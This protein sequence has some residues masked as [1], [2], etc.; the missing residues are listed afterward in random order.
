MSWDDIQ[1]KRNSGEISNTTFAVYR[2]QKETWFPDNSSEW[3]GIAGKKTIEKIIEALKNKI[4]D[5]IDINTLSSEANWEPNKIWQP[6]KKQIGNQS[7]AFKK[8]MSNTLMPLVGKKE[9]NPNCQ[10]F[11]EKPFKWLKDP[12]YA[13]FKQIV[14]GQYPK[15]SPDAKKVRYIRNGEIL[16]AVMSGEIPLGEITLDK[17]YSFV[18]QYPSKSDTDLK[19]MTKITTLANQ[20][21]NEI[22][23]QI[24]KSLSTQFRNVLFVTK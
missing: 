9:K 13:K 11:I 15:G 6:E 7:M 23:T 21:P 19:Q 17:L 18:K 1:T 10:K 22:N 12:R 8:Y 3:D 4:A 2:F 16:T 5:K 20:T 24:K 14:N